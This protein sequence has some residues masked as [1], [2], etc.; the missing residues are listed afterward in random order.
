M[1]HAIGA[2]SMSDERARQEGESTMTSTPFRSV[3]KGYVA[4]TLILVAIVVASL[5]VPVTPE[6]VFARRYGKKNYGARYAKYIAR[7][8]GKCGQKNGAITA[9]INRDRHVQVRNCRQIYKADKALCSDGPCAKDVKAR[10]KTCIRDAGGKA[11]ADAKAIHRRGYGLNR[12]S[13]CCQRT[14]GGGSCL[15]YFSA[16]RFYGSFRYR[17]RLNCDSGD[18]N[19]GGNPGG[20]PCEAACQASAARG[21]AAC[22]A[23]KDPAC[24]QQ[25]EQALQACLAACQPQ[26]PGSPSGAF[27]GDL[28]GRIRAH[29]ARWLPWLVQGWN[30]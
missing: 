29:V 12:C 24:L 6:T 17:G 7:C 11:R 19:P 5:I 9:C 14:K 30:D 21:R 3:R 16:S 18:N 22:K 20:N 8:K 26:P 15:N 1:T 27:L 28:S 13:A 23:R 4:L 25:V 2:C 10:L